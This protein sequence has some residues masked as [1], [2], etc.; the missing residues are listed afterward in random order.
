M[1]TC[2]KQTQ[3]RQ[4]WVLRLVPSQ[5]RRQASEGMQLCS[6]TSAEA[7]GQAPTIQEQKDESMLQATLAM[8]EHAS[9]C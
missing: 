6:Q 4:K 7:S 9:L 5:L 8:T 1:L 3:L 2:L